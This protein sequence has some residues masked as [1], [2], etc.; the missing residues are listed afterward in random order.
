MKKK[1]AEDDSENEFSVD[2]PE[3]LEESDDDWTPAASEARGGR[4]QSS[5]RGRAPVSAKK[6][7]LAEPRTSEDE[8][9]EEEEEEPEEGDEE[10]E[11]EGGDEE[12]DEEEE[13]QPESDEEND[14][15][16]KKKGRGGN[17]AVRGGRGRGKKNTTTA[18]P[19]CAFAKDKGA[20]TD[21]SSTTGSENALPTP[22]EKEFTS[23][24]FV[25]LKA[26]FQNQ[27][28]PPI[29]KIDGKALLQKYVPFEQ[30]GKIMYR[31]TS[32]YSGWS[33]VLKDR[34]YPA[35]IAFKM[36]NRKE[37]VVEFLRDKIKVEDSE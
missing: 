20:E 15:A 11:E 9:E 8:D 21:I 24:A 31:N 16:K 27:K 13:S 14:K 6:P 7:R 35:Q 12:E 23:G 29:W 10:D 37:T 32:T 33:T 17:T 18:I 28:D 2:E 36:Q 19:P 1:Y 4:R 30:D 25:V 26:D 3:E 34:Y 5:R 22:V